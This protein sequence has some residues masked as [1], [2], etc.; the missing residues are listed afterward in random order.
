MARDAVAA[1]WWLADSEL[2]G[3]EWRS[4]R[5]PIG[6]GNWL[7]VAAFTVSCVRALTLLPVPSLHPLD[8]WQST[9]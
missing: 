1:S 4:L 6:A 5:G 3:F 2:K 8:A 9:F 7:G